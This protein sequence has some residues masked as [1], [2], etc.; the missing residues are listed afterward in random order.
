MTAPFDEL[1]ALISER[2][3][4]LRAA[5]V[6]LDAP[7][8]GCPDWTVRDLVVHVG[9]V[10]RSW[11]AKVLA[12]AA[13]APP[14]DDVPD[15][16]LLSWS[17]ASTDVLTTA[18]ADVGPDAECLTWW[19]DSDAP[20]T[21]AAV[22]RHQVQEAALHAV[23]AQSA[24]GA[25]LD[26]PAAIAIDCVD[27]F[28]VVSLGAMGEWPHSAAR[29]NFAATEGPTWSVRLD[30]VAKVTPDTGEADATVS[31]SAADLILALYSRVPLERLHVDGDAAVVRRLFGWAAEST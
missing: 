25:P 29:V 30:D 24:A 4:V 6:D 9:Q 23:D 17:E 16:D 13:G 7:V 21:A 2:S 10:Q 27:E 15:G 14:V 12:G 18:L 26:L 28:L 19:A 1:L 20:S 8:P 11:A 31:G 5:V 22:A 3:A